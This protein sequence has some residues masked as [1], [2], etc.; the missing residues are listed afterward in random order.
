MES[1]LSKI[2]KDYSVV[3][4]NTLK[5]DWIMSFNGQR[6][7]TEIIFSR[8]DQHNKID[9]KVKC[10]TGY[11]DITGIENKTVDMSIMEKVC[12]V[13]S[14]LSKSPLCMGLED[15]G[16]ENFNIQHNSYVVKNLVD[17]TASEECKIYATKCNMFTNARG[18]ICS[19]CKNLKRCIA[20]AK[21]RLTKREE[22]IN[23][24]SHLNHRYM[25]QGEIVKMLDMQKAARIQQEMIIT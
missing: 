6:V 2:I 12:F 1:L 11:I 13:I 10:H 19:S 20:H 7:L 14:L 21:T 15:D 4:Q 17:I 9:L 18:K 22:N 23:I 3:Y 8:I 25:T 24:Y 5:P 16:I